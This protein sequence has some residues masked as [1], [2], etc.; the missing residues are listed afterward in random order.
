MTAPLQL[1][2]Q[3]LG[4]AGPSVVIL[5]GLLGSARNWH[6]VG[7]A[8][9]TSHRVILLDLRNHGESPWVDGMGYGEMSADVGA[10]LAALGIETFTIV[11]HSM[12]GK[13]AMT[14]A[15]QSMPGLEGLV[16]IDIAPVR[17]AHDHHATIAAMLALDTTTLASRGEADAQLG[18]V[19]EERTFR[20]FLLQN[21]VRDADGYCWRVNLPA[22]ADAMPDLVAFP[23][24]PGSSH[25]PALAIVGGRSSYVT[26]TGEAALR[27]RFPSLQIKRLEAAGHWPHAEFPDEVVR[28]LQTF[29]GRIHGE[30]T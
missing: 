5:H 23:E 13:V 26:P 16:V 30:R 2:A 15:L 27:E 11:G 9:A 21:L 29:M 8:L 18:V 25:V 7:R 14:M 24:L 28:L 1:A 10:T 22:I 3:T 6:R 4:S 19:V 12:G 17:Y 20:Q